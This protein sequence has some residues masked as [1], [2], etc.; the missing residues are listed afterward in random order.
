MVCQV[1]NMTA[2]RAVHSG[3]GDGSQSNYGYANSVMERICEKRKQD[4]LPGM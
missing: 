4:G 2:D 3:C 1:C